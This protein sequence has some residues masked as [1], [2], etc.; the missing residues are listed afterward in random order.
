[1]RVTVNFDDIEQEKVLDLKQNQLESIIYRSK[2]VRR[3]SL[4]RWVGQVLRFGLVGG[5]NTM[6]D[7]FVLNSLIWL[8]PTTN[9]FTLLTY[10]VFAFSVGAF[11]S[12]LLN[13]YWTFKN[14]RQIT[15]QE[16]KRFALTTLLGLAWS[17]I[18]LWFVGN[19]LHPFEMNAVLWANISKGIAIA[20]SSLLSYLSMHFWV[21]IHL[22]R[23][24]DEKTP[25][26]VSKPFL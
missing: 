6:V 24:C 10:N 22:S 12:F 7:L 1:M 16:V 3:G 19:F 26:P 25:I 23:N 8:F 4:P 5:L 13:K 20:S 17:T 2:S 14:Q 15:S 18:V 11:N 21:F 9:T